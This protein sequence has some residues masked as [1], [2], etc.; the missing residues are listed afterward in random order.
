[1]KNIVVTNSSILPEEFKKFEYALLSEDEFFDQASS[2]AGLQFEDHIYY[3]ATLLTKDRYDML[4][5]GIDPEELVFYKFDNQILDSSLTFSAGELKIY[6]SHA[7]EKVVEEKPVVIEAP[8]VQEVEKPQVKEKVEEKPVIEDE[9]VA[10]SIDNI[11]VINDND[12]VPQSSQD[13]DTEH[14]SNIL[15]YDDVT[16]ISSSSTKPAKIITFG[17]AKGG[18]G[19]SFT[20]VLTAYRYANAHPN[21]RIAFIDLDVITGQINVIINKTLPTIYD[22]Y[23][24]YKLGHTEFKYLENVKTKNDHF[25]SNIDFYLSP[26]VEIPEITDNMEFWKLVLEHLYR[27]YDCV[28]IDTGIDFRNKE[29]ITTAYRIA[30]KLVLVTNMSIQA[31]KTTITQLQILSGERKNNVFTKDNNMLAKTSLVLTRVSANDSINKL[32]I[33]NLKQYAPIVAAFGNIDDKISQATWYQKW[34][35]FKNDEKIN[36]YLDKIAEIK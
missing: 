33:Q 2:D 14:L 1:L 6:K 21:E 7:E 15:N 35:V 24:Q 25:N 26:S 3:D 16:S 20:S 5:E 4:K 36:K 12:I 31:V 9:P 17:S 10:E 11:A 29:V 28:F 8:K 30:D 23:K 19:K 27:H 18:T 13:L 22:F 34:S 32:V